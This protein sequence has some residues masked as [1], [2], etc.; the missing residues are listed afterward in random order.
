[1]P[2]LAVMEYLQNQ[3]EVRRL[4]GMVERRGVPKRVTNKRTSTEPVPDA[5]YCMKF[6][7]KDKSTRVL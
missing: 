2:A 1:M 3:M 4:L 7:K 6:A 5:M